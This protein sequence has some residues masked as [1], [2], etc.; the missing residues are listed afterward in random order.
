M[1]V[2][3]DPVAFPM[4]MALAGVMEMSRASLVRFEASMVQYTQILHL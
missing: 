4:Y 3:G 2:P 1:F